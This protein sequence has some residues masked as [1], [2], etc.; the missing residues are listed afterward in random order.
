MALVGNKYLTD[1]YL[2]PQ[3]LAFVGKLQAEIAKLGRELDRK[4]EALRMIT[5]FVETCRTEKAEPEHEG[6]TL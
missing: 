5:A 4:Q 3:E 2:S 6:A 1:R